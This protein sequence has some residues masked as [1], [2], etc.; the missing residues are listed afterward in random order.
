MVGRLERRFLGPRRIRQVAAHAAGEHVAAA[1][2]DRIDH[3]AGEAAVFSRHRRGQD[4]CFLDRFLDE[5]VVRPREK[6]VADVD[7]V[8][9]EH[10]V[11]GDGAGDGHLI[12]VR[13]VVGQAGCELG[14]QRRRAAGRQAFD[15]GGA[16]GRPAGA[17]AHQRRLG[18]SDLHGCRHAFGLQRRIEPLHSADRHAKR[19]VYRLEA[20]ELKGDPVLAGREA[21]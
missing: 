4:L 20:G 13:R 19:A 2:R 6:V 7:A 15:L 10:V 9:Q 5:K 1:A 3:A 11:V 21:L 17:R 8:K 18:R 14:D 12:H 16:N